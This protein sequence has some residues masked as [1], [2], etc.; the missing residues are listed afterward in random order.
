MIEVRQVEL[1]RGGGYGRFKENGKGKGT[2][3]AR[4]QGKRKLNLKC[5]PCGS[6]GLQP[7]M[8]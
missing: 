3:T 2:Y 1:G 6:D 8:R 7:R 5:I 4:S